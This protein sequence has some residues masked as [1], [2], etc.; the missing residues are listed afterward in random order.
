MRP[1]MHIERSVS[2]AGS[3]LAAKTHFSSRV[4]VLVSMT[5]ALFVFFF[6]YIACVFPFGLPSSRDVEQPQPLYLLCMGL[7]REL[8]Y[9]VLPFL[10]DL[11]QNLFVSSFDC[12][13]FLLNGCESPEKAKPIVSFTVSFNALTTQFAKGL[14]HLRDHL[15]SPCSLLNLRVSMGSS[16][17]QGMLSVRGVFRG[18]LLGA[19]AL[20]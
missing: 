9:P 2:I 13:T 11:T 3:V 16:G 5:R 10:S 1:T 20:F 18:G 15:S 14:Y 4:A 17:G 6:L 7:Q 8:S 19:E 12:I